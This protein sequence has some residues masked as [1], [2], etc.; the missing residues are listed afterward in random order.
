MWKLYKSFLKNIRKWTRTSNKKLHLF[1]SLLISVSLLGYHQDQLELY[2]A[3]ERDK[4][5]M[6]SK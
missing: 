5:S 2:S 4:I 3:K 6:L 1:Q